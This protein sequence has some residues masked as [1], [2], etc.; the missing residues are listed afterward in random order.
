M[1][2]QSISGIGLAIPPRRK[3]ITR[4]GAERFRSNG[5]ARALTY[6]HATAR[7]D[8]DAWHERRAC[9]E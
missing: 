4:S 3:S 6:S 8:V 1:T 5:N 7:S 9:A 2:R